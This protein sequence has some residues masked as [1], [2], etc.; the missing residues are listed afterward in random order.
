VRKLVK[1]GL[2]I[3]KPVK[4]YS[5]SRHKARMIAK[6]ATPPVSPLFAFCTGGAVRPRLG[7]CSALTGGLNIAWM[8]W[9]YRQGSPRRHG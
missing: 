6:G 7:V 9:W 2:V 1:D 3:R 8:L 5:R 4:I